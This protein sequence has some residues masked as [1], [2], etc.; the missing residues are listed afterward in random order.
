MKTRVQKWGNSLALRIPKALAADGNVRNGTVVD[1]KLSDGKLIVVP[2]AE[3]H[4]TLDGL[5]AG[6][7]RSN[8]HGEVSS[9]RSVGRE[10]W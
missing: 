5:L 1:L 8:L 2:I 4:Y 6:V 3:P 9:G 7:K 10:G